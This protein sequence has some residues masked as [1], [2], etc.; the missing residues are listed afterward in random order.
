M[1]SLNSTESC[2]TMPSAARKLDWVTWRDIL[3]VDQD[4]AR[5]RIV[6][7]EHQP[8]DGGFCPRPMGRQ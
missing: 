5:P 4:A 2:G 6:E 1:V 7:A 3:P 8:R